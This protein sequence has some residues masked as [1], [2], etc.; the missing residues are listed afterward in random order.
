MKCDA[1]VKWKHI[2]VMTLL[3][4]TVGSLIVVSGCAVVPRRRRVKTVVVAK[5]SASIDVV[6]V[7]NAPPKPL[8][9]TRPERP[10]KEAVWM[11]GY[12][13]WNGHKY[14]WV[15]GRWEAKPRGRVWMP[16]HWEKKPRGWV[17]VPGQW[18]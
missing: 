4:A 16:G 5:P 7:Q 11:P 8:V 2:V 14:V 9:E 10:G 18:R 12:W 1:L 13:R 17:W 15:S 3:I 6:Y